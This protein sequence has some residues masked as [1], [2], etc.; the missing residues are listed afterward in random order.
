MQQFSPHDFTAFKW[1][2]STDFLH[3]ITVVMLLAVFLAAELNPFYLKVLLLHFASTPTQCGPTE[4][5]VDGTG[6]SNCYRQIGWDISMRPAC[7]QRTI[8]V[9]QRP[10]VGLLHIY[11]K[12][13]RLTNRI[14]ESYQD[15]ATHVV[16]TGNRLH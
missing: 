9:Y 16:V 10:T 15:G 3:Y 1:A 13:P 8:P 6:S 7:S 14:K 12:D 11:A 4:L 2:G 5:A